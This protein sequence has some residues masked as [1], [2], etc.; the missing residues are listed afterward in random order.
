[1]DTRTY[2][3]LIGRFATGVT[4]I[5]TRVDGVLHGMTA[6]AVSSVSL[7][8]LLLVV[9]VGHG[10]TCLEQL[11]QAEFFG[12]SILSDAQESLSNLFALP[13]PPEEDALRGADYVLTD[14]GVPRLLGTLGWL[15]CRIHQRIAAGDH[16][17]VLG[18]VLDGTRSEEG[19]PLLFYG[20][21]YE[22]LAT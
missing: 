2:R 16:D 5:T 8:P 18:E 15:E 3:D 22:R 20:G 7:D 9:C 11:K 12:V 14:R 21:S 10:S 4:V 13:G 19:R 6:N 1:M 17:L